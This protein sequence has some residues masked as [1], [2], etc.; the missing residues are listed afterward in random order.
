MEKVVY[1]PALLALAALTI[2]GVGVFPA[3]L[4]ALAMPPLMAAAVTS[5]LGT[6]RIRGQGQSIAANLLVGVGMF[7]IATAHVRGLGLASTPELVGLLM[8]CAGWAIEL[9]TRTLG[10]RA[11]DA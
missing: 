2:S 6:Q 10:S 5:V 9:R 8:F 4:F 11:N 3:I 7:T 1:T